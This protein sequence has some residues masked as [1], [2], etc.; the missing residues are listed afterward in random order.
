MHKYFAFIILCL[1]LFS[2]NVCASESSENCLAVAIYSESR[3]ESL[4]GMLAVATVVMNRVEDSRY[5]N[6]VCKV[7]REGKTG[8]CQFQG[9]CGKQEPVKRNKNQWETCLDIARK[10]LYFG[11]R[12][13][14]L[15]KNNA[16][17]FHSNQ[18]IPKWSYKLK[19]VLVLGGH[20]FYGEKTTAK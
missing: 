19:K 3:A 8:Q 16:M 7:V 1:T 20:K 11:E 12:T 9:L 15:L 4:A 2:T 13:D 10:A 6:T 18:V 17:W 5:P 14:I